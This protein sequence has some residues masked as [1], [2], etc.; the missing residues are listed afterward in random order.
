MENLIEHQLSGGVHALFIL[1]TN[2]EGPSLSYPLRK[3]F[4]RLCCELVNSKIPILV[5]ISDPS[6]AASLELADYA[7]G[8]G[9][10]AV[11]LAPPYYFPLSEKELLH[12]LESLVPKL[13]LPFLLY[14]IPS[15]TKIDLTMEV[16]KRAKELGALGIKDS[17]GDMEHLN[18]LLKEFKNSPE[19][20][21]FTGTEKFLPETIQ[22]GGHGAVAGGANMFPKLFVELYKAAE[23]NDLET[24]SRLREKVLWLYQSIYQVGKDASRY[25]QGTKCVLSVMGICKDYMAPPLQRLDSA[26]RRQIEEY[27]EKII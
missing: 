12:Y 25:L 27:M 14:N 22:H 6:M 4:I 11:V 24:I 17:S 20:S 7:K 2:G 16:V 13:A 8:A 10:D 18:S 19:F 21:I 3:E 1:G 5:G 23:V 26:Q 15:H 9:A